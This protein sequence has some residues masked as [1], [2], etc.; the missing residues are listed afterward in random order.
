MK[1]PVKLIMIYEESK[2]AVGKPTSVTIGLLLFIIIAQQ[3]YKQ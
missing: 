1:K 3:H 2:F